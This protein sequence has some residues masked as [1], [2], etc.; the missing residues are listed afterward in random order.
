MKRTNWATSEA[1]TPAEA[2]AC[3]NYLIQ[4]TEFIG[5]DHP[6]YPGLRKLMRDTEPLRIAAIEA[7]R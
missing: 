6:E 2:N 1:R 3:R 5:K 7:R 4:E